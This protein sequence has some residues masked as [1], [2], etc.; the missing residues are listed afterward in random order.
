MTEGEKATAMPSDNHLRPAYMRT[1]EAISALSKMYNKSGGVA[2]D[3]A[4]DYEGIQGWVWVPS[5]YSAIEQGLKLLIQFHTGKSGWGHRLSR[6]YEKLSEKHK[7]TLD[8][9]YE[10][11]VELHSYI[12]LRTLKPF[13]DQLDVGARGDGGRQGGYTT[14]RYFLLE[15]F[16]E[17][18][19]RQP[20]VSIGAML[21]VARGIRYILEDEFIRLKDEVEYPNVTRRLC[22]ALHE[23][24]FEMANTLMEGQGGRKDRFQSIYSGI[25]RLITENVEYAIRFLHPGNSPHPGI[26]RDQIPGELRK[27]CKFM[28]GY[29]RENFFQYLVKVQEGRLEIPNYR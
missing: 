28:R 4:P 23:E 19:A 11:Y 17:D 9:T 20:K 10:G 29:D 25:S 8:R 24:M 21:E 1:A 22:R 27:I 15:G 13:L 18:S 5:A 26:S 12:P 6:L 16:P 14:W 3:M 2:P 7:E